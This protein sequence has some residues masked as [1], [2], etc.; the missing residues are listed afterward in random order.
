ME[1]V[2][3]AYKQTV[4]LAIFALKCPYLMAQVEQSRDVR[5][6]NVWEGRYNPWLWNSFVVLILN[7][8]Y[9]TSGFDITKKM[10]G[11]LNTSISPEQQ[12]QV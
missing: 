7:A 5:S 3:D 9:N 1:S 10:D 4:G 8:Y 11:H 12:I 6:D 2:L